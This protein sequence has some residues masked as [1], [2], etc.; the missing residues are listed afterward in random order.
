MTMKWWCLVLVLLPFGGSEA[1][2]AAPQEPS[3]ASPK[4][5]QPQPAPTT[6]KP[7]PKGAPTSTNAGPPEGL[8]FEYVTP[9]DF[10]TLDNWK[11][12]YLKAQGTSGYVL[13]FEPYSAREFES[14]GNSVSRAS[15]LARVRLPQGARIR[16]FDCALQG[17]GWWYS[18][19]AGVTFSGTINATATLVHARYADDPATAPP[20]S[21]AVVKVSQKTNEP[22]GKGSIGNSA[23]IDHPRGNVTGDGWYYVHLKLELVGTINGVGLRAC[24]VGYAL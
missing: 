3:S 19:R 24:R 15:A 9:T 18:E 21:L 4:Q 20:Y 22:E 12:P 7:P 14:G 5:P 13:G 8:L 10:S 6:P 11:D 1:A 17:G 16:W 2:L 23:A